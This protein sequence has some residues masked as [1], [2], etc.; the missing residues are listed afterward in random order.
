M[1]STSHEDYF[2]GLA[3]DVRSELLR[4]Q[5]V[6]ESLVPEAERCVSYNMPA[7]RARKVFFYFAAFKKHIGVYPPVKA[8]RGLI[9]ELKDFRGPKGN[10]VLPLN[11]PLP[12]E[13]I[14]RVAKALY[15]EYGR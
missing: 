10:L 4:I 8:D 1:S 3:D 13:L 7:F 15:K 12:V 9:R 2:A 6:V 11:R 5:A 14:G